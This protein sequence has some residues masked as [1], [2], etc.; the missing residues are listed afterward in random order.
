MYAEGFTVSRVLAATDMSLG[1][2]YYWLD[3]GPREGPPSSSLSTSGRPDVACGPVEGGAPLYPPIARRRQVVGK[4]RKP[5][6]GSHLSLVARLYRTAER[7]ACDIEERLARP[8]AASP[9]REREVRMLA[10]LVQSVRTLA[11]LAPEGAGGA[12]AEVVDDDP[13]PED[14]DEFRY[15]LAR[16][17]RGF[18]EARAALQEAEQAQAAE[19]AATS[20]TVRPRESGDPALCSEKENPGF[21]LARE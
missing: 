16:R 18:I 21:P 1:T 15:E 5:L 8:S 20:S 7:Q 4:R 12:R 11:S 3:G 19:E 9:A 13:V 17:I 14:I 2:L 10:S 6:S